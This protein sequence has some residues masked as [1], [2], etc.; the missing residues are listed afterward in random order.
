MKVILSILTTLI[1]SST[2]AQ[3]QNRFIDVEGRKVWINTIG[4]EKRKQ[5]QPVIIFE[6]GHGTPMDNWDKVL[7]G[8]S[9]LAPVITYDR[10]GIGESDSFDKMPTIQNISDNL[11]QI[12]KELDVNPPYL[13]VG[14]SLG[15]VYVR[16]FA[17]YHPEMLAGLIIIDPAD[18][19][20]NYQNINDY[21]N[22]LNWE[23]VKVDSLIQSFID[24]RNKRNAESPLAIQREGQVLEAMRESDFAEITQNPLIPNIPVHMITGGR[25][26]APPEAFRSKEYNEE[27]LFRSKTKHRIARWTDVVQSV[28]K[29]MFFYSGDAGHFVQWDDPELIVSSIR[30]VLKDYDEIRKK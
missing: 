15:G 30:L 8:A 11:L 29:G 5:D 14:H 2:Q 20:E 3:A 12:L 21:Y 1:L 17:V 23:K 10:P 7:A 27:T 25:F 22:V 9:S 24:I 28:D 18:F 13:L 16:G 4:L 26:D 6:S 19:T